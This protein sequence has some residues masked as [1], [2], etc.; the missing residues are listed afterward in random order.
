M[1]EGGVE[2]GR[3]NGGGEKGVVEGRVF[4]RRWC[5]G[6]GRGVQKGVVRTGFRKRGRGGKEERGVRNGGVQGVRQ[7]AFMGCKK[8]F[9]QNAMFF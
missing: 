5:S 1:V 6:E 8:N 4:R 9:S 7:N 2:E 3:E